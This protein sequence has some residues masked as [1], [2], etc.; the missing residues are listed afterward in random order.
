MKSLKN[1]LTCLCAE[2]SSRFKTINDIDLLLNV[3]DRL[4]YKY[5][6]ISLNHGRSYIDSPERLKNKKSTISPKK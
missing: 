1:L 2:A 4:R 6:K 3:V 5:N